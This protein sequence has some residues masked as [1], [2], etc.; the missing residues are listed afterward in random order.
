MEMN[1]P[2]YASSFGDEFTESWHRFS[3]FWDMNLSIR[4]S[5]FWDMKLLSYASD[6]YI[7]RQ[8]VTL[9]THY[10]T[11]FL[12]QNLYEL[13]TSFTSFSWFCDINFHQIPMILRRKLCRLHQFHMLLRTWVYLHF[14]QQVLHV[15]DTWI[16]LQ[17]CIKF[18]MVW[19]SDMDSLSYAS[20]SHVVKTWNSCTF[21]RD[22]SLQNLSCNPS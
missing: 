16:Y 12:R 4:F 22:S 5:R 13:C 14:L 2:S 7:L 17:L 18:P 1:S 21:C 20:D 3:C 9:V 10:I 6:S 15:F 8:E 11:M 19:T